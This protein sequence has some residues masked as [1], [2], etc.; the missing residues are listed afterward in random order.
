MTIIS[1]HL[2]SAV[3]LLGLVVF[4]TQPMARSADS[5]ESLTR[6]ISVTG[7][8]VTNV[9]PDTVVWHV[10][11]TSLHK[12]LSRAKAD[13]DKQVKSVIGAVKKLG[14][15]ESDLQTG[16]L[17]ISKEYEHDDYG[18][19]KSFKQ[20]EVTRTITI[21]QRDIERFDDCLSVLVSSADIEARY[22]LESS[23]I[24]RIRAETRLK[25]VAIAKK[26]AEDMAG[27]L[28]ASLGP[29]I[30]LDE[31]PTQQWGSGRMLNA[32]YND[33]SVTPADVTSSSTFAP[34][35]IDIE[36]SVGAVFELR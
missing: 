31:N 27:V 16:H 24:H 21:H 3:C 25:S 22:T 14:V 12:D 18:H 32:S 30:R 34:G 17:D 15:S 7:T 35:S 23:E 2:I 9:V 11:T 33:Y 36:V 19:R 26:K 1:S 13:S 6:T 20:Y 5:G 10:T 28:D 8:A 29:V 4:S